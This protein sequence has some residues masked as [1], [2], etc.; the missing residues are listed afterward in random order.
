MNFIFIVHVGLMLWHEDFES[1]FQ[2]SEHIL[3]NIII[4]I[5]IMQLEDWPILLEISKHC[6]RSSSIHSLHPISLSHRLL[7]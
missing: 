1:I 4:D 5:H 6:L 2:W 3:H 7:V